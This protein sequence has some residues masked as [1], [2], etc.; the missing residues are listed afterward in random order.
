[1]IKTIL[2][3]HTFPADTKTVHNHQIGVM[4]FQ[5]P[6]KD[7]SIIVRNNDAVDII[8][9]AKCKGG[10]LE[11]QRTINIL[12]KP[13]ETT[14]WERS[15]NRDTSHSTSSTVYPESKD[16]GGINPIYRQ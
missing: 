1:M 10:L 14:Q 6:L 11:I 7:F 9:P 2:V 13:T 3:S 12:T 8:S 4:L 15:V 16:F 5:K